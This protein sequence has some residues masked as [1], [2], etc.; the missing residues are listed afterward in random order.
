MTKGDKGVTARVRHPRGAY[1]R[2][3]LSGR[4]RF[5][6]DRGS[7]ATAAMFAVALA[8]LVGASVYYFGWGK[9]NPPVA[10]TRVASEIDAQYH[11]TLIVTGAAFVLA[12]LG[13]AFAIVR[14]RD[15]GNR[16]HYSHGS[17]KLEF[18][19]TFATAVVFLGL[20]LFGYKAWGARRLKP[21]APDAIRVEVTTSQFVYYFRYPG[22]DGKFGAT[23]PKLID[24]A[25]GNPLGIVPNDSAGRDDIVVPT[26][27]VPVDHEIELLIRSQDV[28]HSFFV[29]ELRL[30][31]DSV[32]GM[33]VRLHFTP[34]KIGQYDIVCTQ[35]CG[36][37]HHRMHSYMNVVS[38]SDYEKFLSQQERL[39]QQTGGQ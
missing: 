30:Q 1:G 13:L 16:A 8:A 5:S 28:I 34:E 36:L 20:G 6:L 38:A 35:L 11:L 17:N 32:P 2:A 15:H 22:P 37:G 3:L 25:I 27:T 14:Y 23:N 31:Q 33:T 24:P 18:I 7:A 9:W 29:R 39:L 21:A 12:Q 26:L 19:W 10:I 4:A